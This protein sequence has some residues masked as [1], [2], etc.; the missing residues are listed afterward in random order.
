MQQDNT[1]SSIKLNG[2][3][4]VRHPNRHTPYLNK[5]VCAAGGF[6]IGAVSA[7]FL[8]GVLEGMSSNPSELVKAANSRVVQR[9]EQLDKVNNSFMLFVSL[10]LAP[11]ATIGVALLVML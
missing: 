5:W 8:L 10:A 6:V 4:Y 11:L 3:G 7:G 1:P 9:V 2:K